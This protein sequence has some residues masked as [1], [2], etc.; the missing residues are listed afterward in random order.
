MADFTIR[1]GDIKPVLND[2]LTYSDGSTVDLTGS[3]VTFVM[4]ALTATDVTTNAAATVTNL[5]N[6]A[7]VSYT[8]TTTDTKNAGLFEGYWKVAGGQADGMTFP[9][10][11]GL[12]IEIAENLTTPGGARILSL[13]DAK[14]YLN[15]P[16][17]DR[18][19]DTKLLRFISGL[20]PVIEGITGPV[21]QRVY[22]NETYD[23]GS[24]PYISLRHRPV[25]EVHEVVEFRGTVKYELTQVITP[26]L[27]TTYSYMFEPPGRIVRRTMG[28]G[29]TNFPPGAD[30]VFVTYTA[31]YV[32]VPENIRLG[33]LEL[34]RV[35]YQDTQQAGWQRGGGVPV[36]DE[37]A[38]QQ[39]L[40]FF[41]PN[42][43]RE[44]LAPS[45]RHPSIA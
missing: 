19:R 45:R 27:G 41:V 44:L 23:G 9:T 18:T 6:P 24:T 40:G 43:V 37:L 33:T 34:L 2:T 17:T 28:G 10:V 14:S 20:T 15:I 21:L 31:G 36:S 7:T 12:E 4:R 1:Q 25:I 30:S 39:I 38:G 26:E 8:F 42:R 11:G 5:T 29:M 16:A 3:T 32:Q 35:N 13:T 22:Q